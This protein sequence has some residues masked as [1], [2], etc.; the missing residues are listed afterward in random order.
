MKQSYFSRT[1]DI[2]ICINMYTVLAKQLEESN[3]KPSCIHYMD[4]SNS[5]AKGVYSNVNTF[6]FITISTMQKE[7]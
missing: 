4:C 6:N 3:I 2:Y 1:E 7:I 5:L